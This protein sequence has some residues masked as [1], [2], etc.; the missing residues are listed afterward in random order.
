MDRT[1]TD[2]INE[3]NAFVAT[4]DEYEDIEELD[5]LT[6]GLS[7]VPNAPAALPA[8]FG[9]LERHPDF[10]LG[11][12]GPVVHTIEAIGGHAQELGNSIE[13]TPVDLTVWM[14][15]RLLNSALDVDARKSWIE[16]LRAVADNPEV[17]EPVRNSAKQFLRFQGE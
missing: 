13:R 5:R 12:P 11:A 14:V 6:D 15:N 10:F 1:V 16:T 3:L 8:L 9:V 2:A 4:G 17:A 7:K